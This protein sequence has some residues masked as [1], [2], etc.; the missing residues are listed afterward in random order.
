LKFKNNAEYFKYATRMLAKIQEP[1]LQAEELEKTFQTG[2]LNTNIDIET[3]KEIQYFRG[4]A[5]LLQ[6]QVASLGERMKVYHDKILEKEKEQIKE[7]TDRSI[8]G[9]AD[10]QSAVTQ[11]L[12][13]LANSF[14]Y[15]LLPDYG[16]LTTDHEP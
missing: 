8:F 1:I 14:K 5:S 13:L 7:M 6:L 15:Q 16:S 2:L 12:D 11:V 3:N 4:H 9:G 10:N